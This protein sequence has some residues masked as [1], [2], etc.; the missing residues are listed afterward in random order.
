IGAAL[1]AI[2]LILTLSRGP[3]LG[4]ITEIGFILILWAV[5]KDRKR[6]LAGVLAAVIVSAGVLLVAS[7]PD[8]PLNFARDLP[9]AGRLVRALDATSRTGQTRL[10]T[11]GA[12][13]QLLNQEPARWLV[14]YG[15]D[16]LI[17]T[18]GRVFPETLVALS[19]NVNTVYD[20]AHNEILDALYTGG[21][22]GALATLGLYASA[23]ATGFWGLWPV[24]RRFQRRL[25]WILMASLSLVGAGIAVIWPGLDPYLGIL[26]GLGLLAGAV[27]WIILYPWIK[28]PELNAAPKEVTA[29]KDKP[30]INWPII[31][32]MAT[33]AGHLVEL[34]FGIAVV[35]TSFLF[36]IQLAVLVILQRSAGAKDSALQYGESGNSGSSWLYWG[37]ITVI[38]MITLIFDFVT[39]EINPQIAFV[40]ILLLLC[41][42]WISGFMLYTTEEKS[43]E[44]IKFIALTLTL[45]GLYFLLHLLLVAGKRGEWLWWGYQGAQILLIL[46]WARGLAV[47]SS[48]KSETGQ[49]GTWRYLAYLGGGIVAIFISLWANQ[50]PILADMYFRGGLIYVQARDWL[51]GNAAFQQAL[52]LAPYQDYYRRYQDEAAIEAARSLPQSQKDALM[53]EAE[54]ALQKGIADNPLNTAGFA[55]MGYHY[56]IRA[57]WAGTPAIRQYYLDLA[58]QMYEK[59]IALSP[60]NV[61]TL[62]DA[63]ELYIDRGDVSRA[64]LLGQEAIRLQPRYVPTIALWG[65]IYVLR[66]DLTNAEGAFRQAL[67][68]DSS[69]PLQE[70]IR[71]VQENPTDPQRHLELAMVYKVLGRPADA[72][73][74][75]RQAMAFMENG[76]SPVAQQM[77]AGLQP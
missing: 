34:Q 10:L 57:A 64:A 52:I 12:I 31:V 30:D 20:R 26:A 56:R 3:F 71:M 40:P 4:L 46:V 24:C 43:T 21:I 28:T 39:P 25:L 42:T 37:M 18:F 51:R 11:W 14:G 5:L 67:L 66:G 38:L 23:F 15:S 55:R 2:G 54:A 59:A 58:A 19:D 76:S 62:V 65:D 6:L 61:P 33:V 77:L 53:N 48:E 9:Y 32:L 73:Q 49:K 72:L 68:V 1:Q 36:W 75:V 22:L 29:G 45:A 13:P 8:S 69:Q 50:Q 47:T 16:T 63:A 70:R 60:R 44:R 74:E 17:L 7:Q 35:A 27:I 41:F